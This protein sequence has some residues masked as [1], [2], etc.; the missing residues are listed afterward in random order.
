MIDIAR[1]ITNV[2]SD[3]DGKKLLISILIGSCLSTSIVCATSNNGDK[4]SNGSI[5]SAQELQEIFW[6]AIRI[7]QTTASDIVALIQKGA[8]VNAKD[9][10]GNTPLSLAMC[11]QHRVA[12]QILL[13]NG[14]N[15]NDFRALQSINV[16]AIYEGIQGV[17][18]WLDLLVQ[19]EVNINERDPN[20]NTLLH[21]VAHDYNLEVAQSMAQLLLEFG[22]EI[23][24]TNNKDQTPLDITLELQGFFDLIKCAED[25]QKY[26]NEL[27]EYNNFIALL[28][29][30]GARENHPQKN[31]N[32][33][34]NKTF[35]FL[36]R[37]LV[38][39]NLE[40][41]EE[42]QSLDKNVKDAVQIIR[43][44]IIREYTT[45][46]PS[47]DIIERQSRC[48]TFEEAIQTVSEYVSEKSE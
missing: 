37:F 15:T 24:A 13:E 21:Q 14:A 29:E 19:K 27:E 30:N 8:D 33:E 47:K 25:T 34:M 7:N 9:K 2:P 26:K 1:K 12:A 31:E 16:I 46:S 45:E 4:T 41:T 11:F 44:Y 35:Q 39:E 22:A 36:N 20:G 43:K 28:R 10:Y 48:K 40:D 17:R 42:G 18:E 23:N 38:M 3:M 32:R 5:E 6:D